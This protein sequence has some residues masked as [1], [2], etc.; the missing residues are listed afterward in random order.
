[1][2]SFASGVDF[3]KA[4]LAERRI[5][6]LGEGKR[7]GDIHRLSLDP[8]FNNA[9]LSGTSGAATAGIPAKVLASSITAAN[10]KTLYSGS[11]SYSAIPKSQ[12]AIGYSDY[13]FLWPLPA[14]EITNSLNG[15]IIQ[16]PSY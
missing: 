3:I 11:A 2:A 6:F 14:T 7:W 4:V 5:E 1:V 13:R 8:Q 12:A 10:F 9:V 16:N 15:I